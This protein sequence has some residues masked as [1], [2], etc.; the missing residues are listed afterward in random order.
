MNEEYVEAARI[1]ANASERAVLG[2][3]GS[4]DA[5]NVQRASMAMDR[6]LHKLQRLCDGWHEASAAFSSAEKLHTTRRSDIRTD[7]VAADPYGKT[8]VERRGGEASERRM[9]RPPA[10]VVCTHRGGGTQQQKQPQLT[11]EEKPGQ[12]LTQLLDR[13][14]DELRQP[15][16]LARSLEPHNNGSMR[17]F[18]SLST[19]AFEKQQQEEYRTNYLAFQYGEKLA[20][21]HGTAV[22]SSPPPYRESRQSEYAIGYTHDSHQEHERRT[23][24]D[25]NIVGTPWRGGFSHGATDQTPSRGCGFNIPSRHHVIKAPPIFFPD[26][27]NTISATN[28]DILDGP[29]GLDENQGFAGQEPSLLSSRTASGSFLRPIRAPAVSVGVEQEYDDEALSLQV[30]V[31]GTK[32]INTHIQY[33]RVKPSETVESIAALYGVH[34]DVLYKLNP[35]VLLEG[36][37]GIVFYR[38]A[39][40]PRMILCVAAAPLYESAS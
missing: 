38:M 31:G 23:T 11:Q 35:M 15:A 17:A 16:T 19:L 2:L 8:A 27:T 3:L 30:A 33:H 14:S 22:V 32:N 1:L 29:I 10:L 20:R 34:P 36:D 7:A 21:T 12:W 18:P 26:S 28:S 9:E 24:T 6:R 5:R 25:S 39:L 37:L 13:Y 4:D 40:P